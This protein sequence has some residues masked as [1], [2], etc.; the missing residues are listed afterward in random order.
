[1]SVAL[2]TYSHLY[3][4]TFTMTTLP[5]ADFSR[6]ASRHVWPSLAQLQLRVANTCGQPAARRSMQSSQHACMM[7]MIYSTHTAGSSARCMA[8]LPDV[9]A[10]SF[11]ALSCTCQPV[12]P[13]GHML[14]ACSASSAHPPIP[15]HLALSQASATGT[16]LHA[17]PAADHLHSACHTQ[18]TRVHCTSAARTACKWIPHPHLHCSLPSPSTTRWPTNKLAPTAIAAGNQQLSTLASSARR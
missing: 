9:I 10:T 2:H 12:F 14:S 1:M 13:T 6:A 11:D 7:A 8:W 18:A 5:K 3:A 15:T 16:L 17:R 4:A